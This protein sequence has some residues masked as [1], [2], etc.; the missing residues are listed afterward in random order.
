MDSASDYGS[1]DSSV[2]RHARSPPQWQ[3]LPRAPAGPCSDSSTPHRRGTDAEPV[4][5]VQPHAV[6]ARC[7]DRG[8]YQPFHVLPPH[9]AEDWTAH[10]DR[11]GWGTSLGLC[12]SPPCPDKGHEGGREGTLV[13]W[14]SLSWR[15]GNLLWEEVR[16]LGWQGHGGWDRGLCGPG[17]ALGQEPGVAVGPQGTRMARD[18][19]Q[20]NLSL[21]KSVCHVTAGRSWHAAVLCHSW[22]PGA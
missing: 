11:R 9:P 5:W 2:S 19:E 21:G 6:T 7:M 3:M 10:G 4:C 14:A 16:A 1:E 22:S 18:T 17:N 13:A 12:L 15:I 20:G 8:G